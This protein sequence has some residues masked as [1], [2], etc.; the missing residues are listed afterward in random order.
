MSH[1]A[2]NPCSVPTQRHLSAC[3][4]GSINDNNMANGSIT[5]NENREF[6]GRAVSQVHATY[7]RYHDRC[8][9][10]LDY[11]FVKVYTIFPS[12]CLSTV[13]ISRLVC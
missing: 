3:M 13:N 1:Y 5:V 6:F 7:M 11:G 12:F 10:I 4:L 9:A 2:G 8:L